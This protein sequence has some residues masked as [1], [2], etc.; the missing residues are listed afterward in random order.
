MH[1][2]DNYGEGWGGWGVGSGE[3]EVREPVVG[4]RTN[5]D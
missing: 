4:G 1:N 3:R 5:T 2:Y